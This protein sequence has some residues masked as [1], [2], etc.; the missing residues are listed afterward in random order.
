MITIFIYWCIVIVTC[1]YKRTTCSAA[2]ICPTMIL[3]EKPNLS[4]REGGTKI[5]TSEFF[6]PPSFL[7][8]NTREMQ[9]TG[10]HTKPLTMLSQLT[11]HVI[12]LHT[13]SL[14]KKSSNSISNI[15][16]WSVR[17]GGTKCF[18]PGTKELGQ[19]AQSQQECLIFTSSK[20]PTS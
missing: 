8:N 5:S 13:A 3:Y 11:H 7:E 18:E 4:K 9:F 17:I 1:C 20:S 2:K 14:L 6:L 12:V 16:N 15:F 10:M 19:S